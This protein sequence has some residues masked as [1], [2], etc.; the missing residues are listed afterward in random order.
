MRGNLLFANWWDQYGRS[1]GKRRFLLLLSLP[2]IS[3]TGG[4][5]RGGERGG[6]VVSVWTAQIRFTVETAWKKIL[7]ASKHKCGWLL[8]EERSCFVWWLQWKKLNPLESN[9]CSAIK[10][11]RKDWRKLNSCLEQQEGFFKSIPMFHSLPKHTKSL[12]YSMGVQGTF[13]LW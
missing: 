12:P 3:F 4:E 7:L 11:Q 6:F 8:I 5:C 1:G 2:C 13:L 10:K 9:L